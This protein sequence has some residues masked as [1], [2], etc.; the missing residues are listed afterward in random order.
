M[1]NELR[2]Y[3][4]LLLLLELDIFGHRRVVESLLLYH[5]SVCYNFYFVFCFF[6]AV[7]VVISRMCVYTLLS[8][9]H[10]LFRTMDFFCYLVKCL[11]CRFFIQKI[12]SHVILLK[13]V[14]CVVSAALDIIESNGKRIN[15]DITYHTCMVCVTTKWKNNELTSCR[16]VTSLWFC[17]WFF[18][19]FDLVLFVSC[20]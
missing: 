1:V 20:S 7:L 18:S 9:N 14:Y 17:F 4:W 3:G 11:P 10:S 15:V 12:I 19:R 16:V 5:S 13:M 2:D 6:S 8:L